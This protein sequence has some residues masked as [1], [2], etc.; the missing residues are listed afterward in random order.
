MRFR[1]EKKPNVSNGASIRRVKRA[2]AIRI[3]MIE[4]NNLT[5]VRIDKNFLKEVAKKVLIGENRKERDLS[6]A[7]VGFGRIKEL[8]KKYRGKNQTTDVLAFAVDSTFQIP[9]SRFNFGEIIIC[10]AQVKKNAKKFNTTFRKELIRILIHG[11]LHILGYE[12]EKD[13]GAAEKME[14]K[15]EK[16][17]EQILEA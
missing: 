4:I 12:H 9:D 2:H 16:Y 7:L 15:E 5:T 14:K 10:P 3:L 13:R 11:I 1:P 6:I 17:L 8:N